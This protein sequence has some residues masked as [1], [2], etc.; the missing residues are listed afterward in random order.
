MNTTNSNQSTPAITREEYNVIMAVLDRLG[1]ADLPEYGD[2]FSD[3]AIVSHS[4]FLITQP[5]AVMTLAMATNES[6][7]KSTKRIQQF[8][9]SLSD[10]NDM[11]AE[12]VDSKQLFLQASKLLAAILDARQAYAS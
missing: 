1:M 12:I 7:G 9:E 5:Q 3:I 6:T 4:Q 11:V 10:I 8:I 2:T